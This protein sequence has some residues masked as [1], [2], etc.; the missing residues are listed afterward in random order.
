[1]AR[2]TPLED[3]AR[4]IRRRLG[5]LLAVIA[6]F[7]AAGFVLSEVQPAVYESTSRLIVSIEGEPQSASTVD[8]AQTMARSYHELIGSANIAAQVAQATG[9]SRAEIQDATSFAVVPETQLLTITAAASDPGLAKRI[10][11]GY[12]KVFS[13]VV[14]R[15]VGRRTNAVVLIADSAPLSNEPVG[16][17]SSLYLAVAG[18]L[19]VVAAL[20]VALVREQLDRR[21]RSA[22]DVEAMVDVPVLARIPRG[23]GR[24]DSAAVVEDAFRLLRTNLRLDDGRGPQSVAVLSATSGEGTTLVAAQLAMA[25]G[26][27]G[28]R[29]I[30]VDANLH[31][32]ALAGRLQAVSAEEGAPGLGEYLSDGE[33][34]EN[35]VQ[36]TLHPDLRVIHAGAA[37]GNPAV[38]L[39]SDRARRVVKDLLS[40]ADLV[41]VDCPALALGADAAIV[42]RWAEQVLLVVDLH[43]ATKDGLR[44]AVDRLRQLRV[45]LVGLVINRDR[46]VPRPQATRRVV[47]GRRVAAARR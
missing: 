3:I 38:V 25:A 32:P 9:R 4:I 35:V 15:N 45:P 23:R 19:G 2:E 5:L 43:K 28:L 18:I 14:N 34:V 27:V 42:S 13:D 11:D 46:G 29:T 17:R 20:A 10:A 16:P 7:L 44:D 37:N 24:G 36:G 40:D 30:A 47:P 8:A 1:M 41:V 33:A 12:A 26:E 21:L 22:R 6:G 31:D 39:A